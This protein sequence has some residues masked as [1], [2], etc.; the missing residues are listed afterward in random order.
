MPFG[1]AISLTLGNGIN[2]TRNYDLDYRV[3]NIIDGSVLSRNYAYNAAN[4]IT[5][6]TNGTAPTL[7]QLF[8]YDNL[9]RLSFASG[10]YGD[11][12]YSYDEVG[13]RLSLITDTNGN[14]QAKSYSYNS[15]SHRLQTM[16]GGRN[17]LYDAVGNT[18]DNGLAGFAYNDKNRMASS[19]KNGTTTN[20]QYN[21]LGQR[22]RKTNAADETH[23]I[24]DLEGRL[25][26]EADS[27]GLIS[28]EY[29]Y[30]DGAPLAM[31][32]DEGG[33]SVPGTITAIAPLGDITTAT[34]AFEWQ[35]MG[36]AT[37][38]RLRVYDRAL[39]AWVHDVTYSAATI[40]SNGTCSITPANLALN[41]SSNHLW[42]I[43]AKNGVGWNDWSDYQTFHYV[44]PIP[45]TIST[46]A[47]L[48]SVATTTPAFQW[49]D[50]GNAAEYWLRVYDRVLLAWVHDETYTAT[51]I[52]SNGTCSIT[53]ANLT[54]NISSNHLWRI[55]A[56][57]SGG[58]NDW[59]DYQTFHV[60]GG[61]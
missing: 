55:R 26:S 42:R 30:L 20:Y 29:A 3:Q 2:R 50:L 17:F 44:E 35:D 59:S 46:I 19:T 13:N 61:Q 6:I 36:D 15:N 52:C 22:V 23:Y 10:E 39:L 53:P 40:C 49:Q 43:R 34:P 28:V 38:F 45:G 58:W 37:D 33:P 31:W 27:N 11:K 18:T 9:E 32:H 4:N 24:F 14:S 54:L 16:S 7:S 8:N 25:I 60:T 1:P 56:M 5:A 57:N 21:A 41:F 48:G 47:P 12:S 51:T